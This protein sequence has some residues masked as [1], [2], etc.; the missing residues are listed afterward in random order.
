MANERGVLQG[1]P[2]YRCQFCGKDSAVSDWN[3]E[4]DHCPKCARAYDWLAAQD[5]EDSP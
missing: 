5:W 3:A 4:N 1:I 2:T